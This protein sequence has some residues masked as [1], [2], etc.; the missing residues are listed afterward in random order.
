MLKIYS[1][2][3]RKMYR[4]GFSKFKRCF[5]QRLPRLARV[6]FLSEIQI[7]SSA[8]SYMHIY[9]HIP[10]R[11]MCPRVIYRPATHISR[12]F[13]SVFY[14]CSARV[15]TRV[16]HKSQSLFLPF[17][18]FWKGVRVFPLSMV[19]PVVSDQ[20]QLDTY[21]L[22]SALVCSSANAFN[23]TSSPNV[24]PLISTVRHSTE[25]LA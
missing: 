21:P 13:C 7:K 25:V 20:R 17:I 16:W 8:R 15:R 12:N 24:L 23:A 1:E 18:L 9:A 14:F 3:L 2:I 4:A 19:I 6:A 11:I 22:L 5:A 10:Q